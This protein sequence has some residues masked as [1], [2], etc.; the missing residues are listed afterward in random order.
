MGFLRQR[1]HHGFAA[2]WSA[3]SELSR[4]GPAFGFFQQCRPGS[5]VAAALLLLG[6]VMTTR[7]LF[8]LVAVYVLCAFV[9]LISFIQ[10]AR[11]ILH[12]L[13]LAAVFTLPLAVLGSLSFV[14]PGEIVFRAGPLAV[15]QQGLRSATYVILR[16]LDSL[17][18][19]MLVVRSAG[20]SGV[21]R[22]LRELHMPEHAVAVL[23]IAVAH[24][25]ALGRT[26]YAMVL[27]YRA[28]LV[29]V[30]PLREAYRVTATQGAVLMHK[31]I[32]TS[33]MVH[34][35]MIARGF[36]GRFPSGDPQR[37]F[38]WRDLLVLAVSAG[39]LVMAVTR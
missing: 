3:G 10:I 16:A 2:L 21:L 23:Q 28:R 30:V 9:A 18:V 19:T 35:A 27:A 38:G 24:I 20:I 12:N 34:A 26:A 14:T 33:R 4:G 8:L 7:S 31:S 17:S 1:A 5:R 29:N 39:M 6:A 15:T 37:A 22:G 11:Y 13:A 32:Q 25:H 36:D